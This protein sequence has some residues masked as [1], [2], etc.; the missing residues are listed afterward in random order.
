MIKIQD[1]TI[2]DGMQQ[3]NV[4]KNF[5]TK[6]KILD[7]LKSVNIDSLEVGMCSTIE[8]FNL[9]SEISNHLSITQKWLF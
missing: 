4:N 1:N 5:N 9:L 8:D 2:R 7:L 6:L 3:R